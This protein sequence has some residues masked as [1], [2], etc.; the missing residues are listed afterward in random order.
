M[1]TVTLVQVVETKLIGTCLYLVS[2]VSKVYKE[3]KAPME[4]KVHKELRA[5]TVLKVH[6]EL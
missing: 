1:L 3:L 2:R 4:L 5:L 6:R